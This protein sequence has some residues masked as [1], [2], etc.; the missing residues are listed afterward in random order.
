MVL[1]V[2]ENKGRVAPQNSSIYIFV[3]LIC[4]IFSQ[5][6]QNK[7]IN[8]SPIISKRWPPLQELQSQW[9]QSQKAGKEQHLLCPTLHTEHIL[10]CRS[11]FLLH[12]TRACGTSGRYKTQLKK[13]FI[14]Y[15]KL[16]W[17]MLNL[18]LRQLAWRK[19]LVNFLRFISDQIFLLFIFEFVIHWMLSSFSVSIT[20]GLFYLSTSFKFG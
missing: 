5:T 14:V 4:H 6:F 9:L 11:S 17:A 12:H 7:K 2:L 13:I 1:E 15:N 3:F 10:C 8:M 18:R 20:F 19:K 16:G